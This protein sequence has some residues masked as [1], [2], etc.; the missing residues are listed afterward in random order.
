MNC[1]QLVQKHIYCY[2]TFI[3]IIPQKALPKETATALVKMN[4]PQAHS[5]M[6]PILP[7]TTKSQRHLFLLL[8]N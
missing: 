4:A 7:N 8:R 6:P 3:V 5:K 1:F 2:Y